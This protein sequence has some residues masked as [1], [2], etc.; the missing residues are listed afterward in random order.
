M[1]SRSISISAVIFL[2]CAGVTACGGDDDDGGGA[3]NLE[4]CKEVCAKSNAVPCPI[5]FGLDACNQLCDA[6]AKAPVACQKALKA[7]SDCQLKQA[8]V[9]AIAGC[10]AEESAYQQACSK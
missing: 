9:C 1:L 6:H 4:S 7:V 3:A 8:D 5:S 10:D 2:V